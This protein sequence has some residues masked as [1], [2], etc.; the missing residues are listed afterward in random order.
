MSAKSSRIWVLAVVG[1]GIFG[2]FGSRSGASTSQTIANEPPLRPTETFTVRRI[3][4]G[5]DLRLY[6]QGG[7][8]DGGL[9]PDF[10]GYGAPRGSAAY[11]RGTNAFETVRRF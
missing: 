5:R 11:V 3:E 6:D 2:G 9:G 1:C 10:D 4:Q 7:F 8:Y